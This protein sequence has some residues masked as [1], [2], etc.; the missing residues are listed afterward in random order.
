MLSLALRD[1]AGLRSSSLSFDPFVINRPAVSVFDADGLLITGIETADRLVASPC[2][3]VALV[4]S[5]GGDLCCRV[6]RCRLRLRCP[7]LGLAA[8]T[9]SSC[10]PC[11]TLPACGPAPPDPALFLSFPKLTH[12]SP[13]AL[14]FSVINR[15]LV[16]NID[17]GGLLIT[18]SR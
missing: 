4:G 8:T 12:P 16:S 13:P 11:L 18:V 10:L 2:T 3:G 6:L 15:P 17:V 7:H 5:D 9:G 14:I 1:V